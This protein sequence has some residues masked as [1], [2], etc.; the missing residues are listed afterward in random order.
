M[1]RF[2]NDSYESVIQ[3]DYAGF[4]DRL[5]GEMDKSGMAVLEN[6]LSPNFLAELR[7]NVEQLTP[8]C[9]QNGKRK[10]LI[11]A[12]L[13]NTGFWEVAFSDFALKL[14][15]DILKRF[16]VQ[17][18]S[19]DIHPAVNI[20]LGEQGQDTVHGWHFDATYLT[21]AMPVVMPP[22]SSGRD[23]KFRIW[24][25]VRQFSQSKWQHKLYSNVAET[26]LFQRM[27]KNYAINFVPGNLYFFYGFR[28]FHGTDDLD[29]QQLRAN[30]LINFGGPFF[31]LQKGKVVKYSGSR[32]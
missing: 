17:L 10:Y 29:G 23:G 16:N 19:A 5:R 15:N 3:N 32:A 1:E 30:C 21:I 9:Y 8:I 6:F 11:G 24:P 2:I 4:V 18:E 27:A 20:L 7:T 31:D 25:N 14:S 26:H 22:P 28:S 12:D 13:Q